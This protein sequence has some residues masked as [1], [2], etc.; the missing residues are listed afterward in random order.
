M[1]ASELLSPNFPFLSPK[2]SIKRA[3]KLF[4]DNFVSH[5]AVVSQQQIEGILSAEV[6]PEEKDFKGT[7]ADLKDDFIRAQVL[8]EQHGLEIFEV[9]AKLELSSVPVSDEHNN[10]LGTITTQDLLYTL[11]NYYSF[12]HIGGL[13]VLSMGLRDYNLSEISRIVESN[14]AKILLMYMDLDEANSTIQVT[15][16]INSLDI[17]R[18]L[19]TFER[20]KYIVEFHQPNNESKD[21]MQERYDMLMKMLDL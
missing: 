8:R 18:I 19:A 3:R 7:I 17:S 12:K 11:S 5:L 6:I 10:Y 9:M 21:D 15:L 16:K 14:N 2:D 20:F 13:I 1:I 4:S